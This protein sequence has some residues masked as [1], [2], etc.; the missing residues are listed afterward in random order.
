MFFSLF[1][2]VPCKQNSKVLY[3]SRKLRLHLSFALKFGGPKLQISHE[4]V[5]S[6][7]TDWLLFPFS[8]LFSCSF[9]FLFYYGLMCDERSHPWL[10][11]WKPEPNSDLF[12]IFQSIYI[13]QR[14]LLLTIC[15]SN[16][17]LYLSIV[18]L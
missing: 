12:P 7:E 18:C 6:Y 14:S 13:C 5:E 11:H 15:Y 17:N 16:Y 3:I 8:F 4:N 9:S 10:R 1:I 2:F